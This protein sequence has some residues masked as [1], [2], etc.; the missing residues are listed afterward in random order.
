M[1]NA[2]KKRL[3]IQKML[4]SGYEKRGA[5]YFR[6][7]KEKEIV[8]QVRFTSFLIIL[9]ALDSKGKKHNDLAK[10]EMQRITKL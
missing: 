4:E 6:E 10:R 9:D 7:D 1:N 2:E 3:I 8:Y 5:T